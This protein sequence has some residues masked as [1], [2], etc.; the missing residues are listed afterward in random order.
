MKFGSVLVA[1]VA[2]TVSA[3]AEPIPPTPSEDLQCKFLH[4]VAEAKTFLDLPTSVKVTFWHELDA[5]YGEATE[6]IAHRGAM[7]DLTGSR[8]DLPGR[9]FIRAGQVDNKWFIWFE[10]GGASY[11][12]IVLVFAE[13]A[14]QAKVIAHLDYVRENPCALTDDLLGGHYPATSPD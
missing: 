7:F 13:T 10:Q 11:R 2:L 4:P 3:L 5:H 1:F 14:G 6:A 8:P 9:R 12:K